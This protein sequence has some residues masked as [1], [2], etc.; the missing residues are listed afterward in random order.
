MKILN[1]LRV[2]KSPTQEKFKGEP[3]FFSF[4]EKI[5]MVDVKK[6]AEY[7]ESITRKKIARK[8]FKELEPSR[9]KI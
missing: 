1:Y 3:T 7:W 9:R 8:S 6:K 2:K 4:P 5:W